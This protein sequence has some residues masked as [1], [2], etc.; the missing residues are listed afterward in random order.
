MNP[1]DSRLKAEKRGRKL[2]S[3]GSM[4]QQHQIAP[5][6]S[7]RILPCLAA[8]IGTCKEEEEEQEN[9]LSGGQ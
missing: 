1:N 9:N 6:S 2:A 7:Y 8:E 4:Q 3:D 5:A